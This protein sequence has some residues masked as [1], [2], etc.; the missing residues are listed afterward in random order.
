M[1]VDSSVSK[2]VRVLCE[3][4]EVD[5]EVLKLKTGLNYSILERII[6]A[7]LSSSYIVPIELD[8]DIC[9]SCPLRSLCIRVDRSSTKVYVVSSYLKRLCESSVNLD[10]IY[11]N[12]TTHAGYTT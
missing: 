4:G 9:G 7:L 11:T 12:L 5:I 6:G 10:Y 2:V 8:T 3:F 1:E